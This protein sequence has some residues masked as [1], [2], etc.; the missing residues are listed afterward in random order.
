MR[1]DEDRST[2][3]WRVSNEHVFS[4]CR[5]AMSSEKA[6]SLSLL[7]SSEWAVFQAKSVSLSHCS[8]MQCDGESVKDVAIH[9]TAITTAHCM[10]SSEFMKVVPQSLRL[11]LVPI[12]GMKEARAFSSF[13]LMPDHPNGTFNTRRS[14]QLICPSVDLLITLSNRL[15]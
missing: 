5:T 6:I 10:D 1:T 14:L 12:K 4:S 7:D 3:N 9:L 11:I 15:I 2:S 13:K 8:V